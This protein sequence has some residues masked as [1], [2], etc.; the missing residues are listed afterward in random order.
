[1]TAEILT[2]EQPEWEMFYTTFTRCF[3]S[4]QVKKWCDCA[5]GDRHHTYETLKLFP[6]F[7]I[8]RTM[9]YLQSHGG[10]CDC[11]VHETV[12]LIEATREMHLKQAA[13]QG[14][15]AAQE[16]FALLCLNGTHAY[17]MGKQEQ[18]YID[19]G[20]AWL[21]NSARLGN[22]R[23]ELI[24]KGLAGKICDGEID[25]YQLQQVVWF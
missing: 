6:R 25:L 12:I 16:A 19:E 18:T 2:S 22:V 15:V 3:A 1:M 17:T 14:D 8:L 9:Q 11:Q 5:S 24:L 10:T 7:S 4:G 23:A 13:A 20:C 21:K